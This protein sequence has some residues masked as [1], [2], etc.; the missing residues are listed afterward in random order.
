MDKAIIKTFNNEQKFTNIV[1]VKYELKSLVIVDNIE[2]R[3]SL[4]SKGSKGS[5]KNKKKKK[6]KNL[7]KV[8]WFDS[9]MVLKK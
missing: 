5:K 8:V 9:K 6:K 7:L 4:D 1:P 2:S 3:F